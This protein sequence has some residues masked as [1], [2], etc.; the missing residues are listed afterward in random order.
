MCNTFVVGGFLRTWFIPAGLIPF[1]CWSRRS[2]E[3]G[4]TP[5][6]CAY[7]R[8]EISWNRKLCPWQFLSEPSSQLVS[9]R[10]HCNPKRLSAFWTCICS[11]CIPGTLGSTLH[12]KVQEDQPVLDEDELQQVE[13]PLAKLG[14]ISWGSCLAKL[15]TG[16]LQRPYWFLQGAIA[17]SFSMEAVEVRGE[18]FEEVSRGAL[19]INSRTSK[20]RCQGL[21][22][23]A[24]FS[25]GRFVI[26]ISIN[27]C[28]QLQ[29]AGKKRFSP[30]QPF[31]WCFWLVWIV[32]SFNLR[33]SSEPHQVP[34]EQTWL[35]QAR[36]IKNW[37][38]LQDLSS[39]LTGFEHL[40]A[41]GLPSL[42]S[43]K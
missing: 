1:W 12:G 2:W 37:H 35:R 11:S 10:T 31:C 29:N 8:R 27:V 9:C 30:S 40:G 6:N 36:D 22:G 23:F 38:V 5:S 24:R 4:H 15:Q 34:E 18:P 43:R 13:L 25:R 19:V 41:T 7:R 21:R 16:W 32:G 3:S 28:R 14:Q 26:T 20:K 17:S 33:P 42:K 39:A